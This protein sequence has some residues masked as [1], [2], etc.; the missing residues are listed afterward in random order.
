[1]RALTGVGLPVFLILTVLLAGGASVAMGQA[2]ARAWRPRALVV[3]YAL[4]LG[5]ADRFLSFALFG[6][7]LLSPVGYVVDTAVL[8]ALALA[9]FQATRAWRLAMQYPWLYERVGLFGWRERAG[10]DGASAR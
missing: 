5:A 4:L 6:A 9:A 8:L 1:M 7:P 10:K 3:V 2:L